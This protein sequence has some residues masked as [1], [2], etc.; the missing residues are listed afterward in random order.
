M[1]P[2]ALSMG[3]SLPARWSDMMRSV[4]PTSLPAM[5]T[6]GTGGE[7]PRRRARSRSMSRPWSGSRSSSWTAAPTPRSEKRLTTV[8]HIGQLLAVKITTAF[9]VD[10][11]A[12]LS[13][14]SPAKLNKLN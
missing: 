2:A 9:S 6:A 4:E 1:A 3:T 14:I 13:I 8:W 10:S 12:T 5:K 7:R 11:F